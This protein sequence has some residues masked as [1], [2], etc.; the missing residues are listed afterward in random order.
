MNDPGITMYQGAVE[1]QHCCTARFVRAERIHEQD[2][3]VLLWC[4]IVYVFDVDHP[5]ASRAYAW[6]FE[7]DFATKRRRV[8]TVLGVPP[9]TCARDAVRSAFAS[10]QQQ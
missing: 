10:G 1:R 7:I 8:I 5:Q 4:G 9:V 6:S 2:N 3:G